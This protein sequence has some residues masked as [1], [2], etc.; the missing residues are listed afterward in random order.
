MIF[1]HEGQI[2]SRAL[3]GEIFG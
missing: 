3:A 1:L 2:N